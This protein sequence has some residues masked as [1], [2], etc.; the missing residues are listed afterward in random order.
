MLTGRPPFSGATDVETLKR[1]AFDEPV[2]P[3]RLRPNIPRDLEAICLKC[4]EKHPSRRYPTAAALADD[5]AGFSRADPR[6]R[7]RWGRLAAPSTGL[8]A[9]PRPPRVLAIS[10]LAGPA[11]LGGARWH[12][13]KFRSVLASPSKCARVSKRIAD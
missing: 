1:V 13:A 2:P 11:V 5:F 12:R 3:R 7:P 4:L 9:D 6:S 8:A 10:V